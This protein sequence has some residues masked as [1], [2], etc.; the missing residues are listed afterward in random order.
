MEIINFIESDD[1]S[2]QPFP[3][4]IRNNQNM[5]SIILY[6]FDTFF[7]VILEILFHFLYKILKI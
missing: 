7:L 3:Q 1:Y 6:D 2:K 5:Q 4:M